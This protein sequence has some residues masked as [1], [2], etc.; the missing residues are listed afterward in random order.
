M[1]LSV[2]GGGSWGTALGHQMVRRGHQ[3]LLWAREPEVADGINS[4]HRNPLFLS[5]LDLHPALE[6]TDD[7]ASAV[8]Y[9]EVWLW[10]VPVQFS[11]SVMEQL[12]GQM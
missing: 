12:V 7:L 8:R 5:D 6:A 4:Q 9:A 11:R 1:R 10:V 3:V 2:I